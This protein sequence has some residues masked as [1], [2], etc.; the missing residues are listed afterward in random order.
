LLLGF[1]LASLSASSMAHIKYL[2]CQEQHNN[3]ERN[4]SIGSSSS[5]A[6]SWVPG[7]VSNHA[8]GCEVV[9]VFRGFNYTWALGRCISRRSTQSRPLVGHVMLVRPNEAYDSQFRSC[10]QEAQSLRSPHD[11]GQTSLRVCQGPSVFDRA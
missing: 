2:T 9:S 1:A 5:P 10:S 11:L 6:L 8:P 7:H 3:L 4:I